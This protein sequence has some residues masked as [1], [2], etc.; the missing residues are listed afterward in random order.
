MYQKQLISGLTAVT[1]MVHASLYSW[2]NGENVAPVQLDNNFPL[3]YNQQ[4]AVEESYLLLKPYMGNMWYGS[5]EKFK[6]EG[7]KVLDKLKIENPEFEWSS[8]IRM[9]FSRY[10]PNHDDWDF[11]LTGTYVYSNTND[12]TDANPDDNSFFNELLALD[13]L[14]LGNKGHFNWRLNYWT[15]DLC[16]GR[17]FKMTSQ[18]VFH[19]Y[20]GLRGSW[21]YQQSRLKAVSFS[22]FDNQEVKGNINNNFW[23]VGPRFGTHFTFYFEHHFSFLANFAASLLVGRQKLQENDDFKGVTGGLVNV[24]KTRSHD[25]FNVIRS[26][27]EGMVGLGWERWVKGGTV[28]IAP[29]VAFEGSLWFAMNQI[30]GNAVGVNNVGQRRH[31]NLGLMGVTFNF[32]VDF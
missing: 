25:S 16:V 4:W 15:V 22:P 29:S 24:Q 6:A 20:F 13:K 32:Q 26:N 5:K 30:Y 1:L 11:N 2:S 27:L 31:G 23:G 21:Q 9:A 7:Q 14:L 18:V 19:P 28:R 10:L 12:R 17:L 3:A 8:G